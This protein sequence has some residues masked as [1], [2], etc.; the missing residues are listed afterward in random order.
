M[1]CSYSDDYEPE[2]SWE[3]QETWEDYMDEGSI[4]GNGPE[5]DNIDYD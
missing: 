1:C 5:D 3:E 4:S 2:N